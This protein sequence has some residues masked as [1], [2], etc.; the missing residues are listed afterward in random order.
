VP[1][2]T[3]PFD[4]S[5]QIG[6]RALNRAL[7]AQHRVTAPDD[8]IYPHSLTTRVD[9]AVFALRGALEATVS[10]PWLTL[11][12]PGPAP[13]PI[14]PGGGVVIRGR[15][16]VVIHFIVM[17]RY[18][19]EAGSRPAPAESHGELQ[20]RVEISE[21]F[22]PRGDLLDVDLTSPD[23][24]VAFVPG[25][26]VTLSSEEIQ[27]VER[28]LRSILR[29]LDPVG[30]VM[31]SAPE[32]TDMRFKILPGS[33]PTVDLLWK[34]GGGALGA[35]A[36][37]AA[38][39]RFL[40][41][42][43]GIA[44]AVSG[45]FLTRALLGALPA[46][47]PVSGPL[48]YT[49]TF[50]DPELD[51]D[52]GEAVFTVSGQAEGVVDA[53]FTIRQRMGIRLGPSGPYLVAIGPV[54]LDTDPLVG[55][56]A[57][58]TGHRA[59]IERLL[60]SRRDELLAEATSAL[61]ALLTTEPFEAVVRA[62]RVPAAGLRFSAVAIE[63]E[64][65]IVQLTVGLGPWPPVDVRTP[66]VFPL[67]GGR[68]QLNAHQSWIPGGQVER[69]RWA[70]LPT[71]L[72][73][74]E[75][76]RFTVEAARAR[77]V[78]RWRLE[79]S[80]HQMSESGE[81]V[82]VSGSLDFVESVALPH[83]VIDYLMNL[84]QTQPAR[85]ALLSRLV[86]RV[87]A[88][89]IPPGDP[90]PDAYVSPLLGN[91]ARLPTQAHVL[92]HLAGAPDELEGLLDVL[93]QL[94]DDQGLLSVVVMPAK[95]LE[96]QLA[97]L[98]VPEDVVVTDDPGRG[99]AEILGTNGKPL[100]LVWPV[101][102]EE[103]R[104]FDG[105]LDAQKLQSVLSEE[106][107]EGAV[108][109]SGELR[110]GIGI[111]EVAPDFELPHPAGRPVMLRRLRGQPVT[112]CFWASWA[113]PSV[114]ALKALAG[115]AAA[116]GAGKDLVAVADGDGADAV[117]EV[118]GQ[119]QLDFPVVADPQREI[120]SAYGINCWPTTIDI[121]VKGFVSRIIYGGGTN[122]PEGADSDKPIDQ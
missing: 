93:R 47:P 110:A 2:L 52:A 104:R 26:G 101:G 69:Y 120:A 106:P 73:F 11:E 33:P 76:E 95:L 75:R 61:Q 23:V 17:A 70:E 37:D 107:F 55:A 63:P 62:L 27:Q 54:E 14:E 32:V 4:V 121:D 56:I 22:S 19:A 67:P 39:R 109:A 112:L 100:T 74:D 10:R 6:L 48:G 94:G 87:P 58:L 28:I 38:R 103:P 97:Q 3:G 66:G 43:N 117:K 44:I 99:W 36:E 105:G 91:Y 24:G 5:I 20:L 64:G 51:L 25:A 59:E 72:A 77:S 78:R 118:L 60:A 68:V 15:A 116:D 88:L 45:E 83:F 80:G 102:K 8:E 16:V 122:P 9:D 113:E 92:I 1:D 30:A 85:K 79:V 71:G 65:V 35:G 81:L 41:D 18:A 34:L 90:P 7:A 89:P 21:L 50:R 42:D 29:S 108:V 53:T 96:G 119:A 114:R 84:V 13:G 57:E 86:F 40:L 12:E 115:A 31:P 98:K 49:L 46:A 111:G 82:P